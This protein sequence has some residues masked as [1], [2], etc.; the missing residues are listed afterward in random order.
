VSD[1]LDAW[2]DRALLEP[3]ALDTGEAEVL[4]LGEF[5]H[6]VHEKTDFRIAMA[7]QASRLGFK[8]W[9]EELGW[10]DGRRLTQYFEARDEAVFDRLSLFGWRGDVRADRDDRPTGIFRASLEAYPFDLMRAEQTRFYRTLSPEAL[11]GF[12]VAAGHD[13]GYVDLFARLETT[14]APTAW[15]AALARRPGEPLQEE[16]ARL[17]ALAAEAPAGLDRL[18]RADL[19]ALI[20]GLTYTGLV[21]TAATYAETAPAMAFREDAMKRR[22]VDIRA[23][24]PGKLVLM[25][26]ALHLVR[27]DDAITAPGIVGPGGQG[28]SSLGHHLGQELG[29]PM[30]IIWMIYGGGEDSQPLPDLPRRADFGPH[31]LNARLAARFDRPVLLDARTA[32]DAPVRIAHMYN[33]EIETHLPGVVDALWFTPWIS[34]LQR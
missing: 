2:L 9:A 6:F 25:G 21:Q 27:D 20:D 15:T 24:A 34:P 8:V 4:V 1:A 22:L 23:L 13:G 17:I 14:S 28:T 31:T 7:Q 26:H 11:Y 10:S 12:D 33:T 3:G 29:L 32:P 30:F 18:A 19:S 5:N 16:A